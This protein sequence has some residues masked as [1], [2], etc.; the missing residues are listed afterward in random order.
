MSIDLDP[1]ECYFRIHGLGPAPR[2]LD[3]RVIDAAVPRFAEVLAA[4]GICATFFVVARQVEGADSVAPV[5]RSLIDAGHEIGNHSYRHP[6]ELARRT[7]ADI[8]REIAR[9]HDLLSDLGGAPVVGFR[10]PG[11]DLSAP[12]VESLVCRGYRY[13]SS[14][15][16][17][18]G[19]YA[20]KAAVMAMMRLAGRPSGAVLTDPRG[21]LASPEPY[22]VDPRKPWRQG[23]ADLVE[24]PIA[25]TPGARLPSIG[26]SLLL[27]PRPIRDVL[28]RAMRRRRFFNFELHGIDLIDAVEDGIP[29]E[30]V[31][32][33]PDLRRT[34][35]RKRAA[36]D[37]ILDGLAE[38]G[39]RFA[40][41]RDIAEMVHERGSM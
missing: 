28:L 26:T 36:L 20:A 14:L 27:A 5:L 3:R 16:P 12:M 31:A 9:A 4:R 34:V 11:Y 2:E 24:L 37:E 8:D 1:V 32:R 13:D 33:Q 22:R 15:F 38:A 21:L 19:Y 40:P 23:G 25:V 39:Y 6:Y 17:A 29:D 18:P 41:L 35:A 30:L 7:A 10:A